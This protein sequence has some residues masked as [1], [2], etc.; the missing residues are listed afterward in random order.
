V[1]LRVARRHFTSVTVRAS[2]AWWAFLFMLGGCATAPPPPDRLSPE[3][4]KNGPSLYETGR[5]GTV[6]L[7]NGGLTVDSGNIDP[8]PHRVAATDGDPAS[9]TK[10]SSTG[11]RSRGKRK[12]QPRVTP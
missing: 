5:F 11:R 4:L 10:A 6:P 3:Q 9:P 1:K 8:H 2:L 12:P 7:S